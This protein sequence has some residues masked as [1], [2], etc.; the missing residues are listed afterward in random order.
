MILFQAI[1]HMAIALLVGNAIQEVLD[2]SAERI[3]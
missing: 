1:T 3:P 2:S